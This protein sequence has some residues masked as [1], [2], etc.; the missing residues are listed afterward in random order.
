MWR[1][2]STLSVVMAFGLWGGGNIRTWLGHKGRVQRLDMK[3]GSKAGS[4]KLTWVR[5]LGTKAGCKKLVWVQKAGHKGKGYKGWVLWQS[6]KVGHKGSTQRVT[7]STRRAQR[8]G[9]KG[10][11]KT[12]YK[13]TKTRLHTLCAHPLHPWCPVFAFFA[14]SLR[15]SECCT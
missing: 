1:Y 5:R 15:R 2:P 9:T 13:G 12:M 7:G 11:I 10:E 6:I 14:S 4:K 8:Q 3:A